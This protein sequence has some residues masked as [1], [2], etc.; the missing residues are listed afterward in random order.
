MNRTQKLEVQSIFKDMKNSGI[1]D[2]VTA[3]YKKAAEYMKDTEI[4]AA[5]VS[6]N[7]ICQGEQ[8]PVLWPELFYKHGIKINFAH[9][10]FKW[11]NEARGKAAVYCI[12]AGFSIKNKN[13]KKLYQYAAVNGEPVET[14]AGQIN[15]YLVDAPTIFIEK[16]AKPICNVPEMTKGSSPTDDG[17]FLLTQEEKDNLLEHDKSLKDIIRPYTGAREYLHNIP[18]YCIWLKDVSPAKYNHSKEIMNRLA[19]IKEFRLKSE[20]PATYKFAEFP[21]LFVEIRQPVTDYIIIPRHS[22]ENRLYIP[23][24]FLSSEIIAG[25]AASFIPD[26]GLYEFGVINSA[27]HMAW[28]RY[29]CGR[30]ELRYRYSA[31]IVYNN[32]SWPSPGAKQ[33]AAIERAAQGVLDA[34]AMFPES[35]LAALYDPLSMP[36]KLVM[37][38]Q[39]LDKAVEA[40]YGRSF[41]DDGRRVAHLF[42]LYQKLSARPLRSLLGVF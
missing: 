6:T 39:K 13:I 29:V 17:N 15:A 2:Y 31:S 40:A 26:A 34:R 14:T 8:V 16:R 18:R 28:M 10:T 1:L 7:S 20:S 36:P 24:G 42:E 41:D 35:S 3:W 12:I 23:I 11:S 37:A 9:Q 21:S 32:F 22:S 30:L 38:H 27:M 4:E 5:F 25:D 19:S 33:K